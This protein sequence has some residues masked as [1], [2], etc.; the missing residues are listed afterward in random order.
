MNAFFVD[1]SVKKF[2]ETEILQ[3]RKGREESED[4]SQVN[5]MLPCWEYETNIEMKQIPR[6]KYFQ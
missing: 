4:S 2:Q 5:L 3:S 1:A 6:N